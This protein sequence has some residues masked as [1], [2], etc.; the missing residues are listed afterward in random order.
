MPKS[1]TDKG[2]VKAIIGTNPHAFSCYG[3][4]GVALLYLQGTVKQM[5]CINASV[6]ADDT[7]DTFTGN[8][9]MRKL[10]ELTS[11]NGNRP[12]VHKRTVFSSSRYFDEIIVRRSE[13][14]LP[15]VNFDQA[16]V[17]NAELL[18][19]IHCFCKVGPTIIAT[20]GASL[21]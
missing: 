14:T 19:D 7:V 17:N 6:T 2:L 9:T 10:D 18:Y 12:P 1:S 3:T 11:P 5:D 16:T 13:Q 20:M 15:I 8:K 4:I 21:Q